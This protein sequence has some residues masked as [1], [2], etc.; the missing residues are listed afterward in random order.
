MEIGVTVGD[1]V[2]RLER[3]AG[4]FDF[5]EFGL[6]EAADVPGS[7]DD[8]RLR[9]ALDERG[10]ALDVHL[11]FKQDV[12]T[13]VLE[14]NE[15]IVAHQERLLEW[16]GGV[17][18]RK[19]V[20]HGTVRNPHD[21]DQRPTFASQLAD[22]VAAGEDQGVEVVVE[23][24]GHQAHGLPL[25]V[26][27]DLAEEVDAPVCFDVGHAYMEDGND[28]VERFLRGYGDRI[29]HLHVHDV[30]GRGDTH[31]PVGAGEVDYGLLSGHLDDF[32]GT[33]AVEVFTDDVDLLHD[34]AGRVADVLD[35]SF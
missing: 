1:S 34:T 35:S 32:D 26:L 22:I 23:N 30:R 12:S 4:E 6:A 19:A 29:S 31:M 2:D 7:I 9:A 27:G 8:G 11:P 16:A 15:A 25:S 10:L 33:V 14:I 20:L 28:G 13:P 24:V 21:T 17:G 3:T 18:A 5:A